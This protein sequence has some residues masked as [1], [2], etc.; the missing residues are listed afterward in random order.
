MDLQNLNKLQLKISV[1]IPCFNESLGIKIS[2]ERLYQVL[3]SNFNNFEI[4]YIN[5]GSTD[6]T[7]KCLS[8]IANGCRESKII[9]FSRNF[10]HQSA[11]SC[12][13]KNASGDYIIIMDADLQDPPEEIPK[14]VSLAIEQNA[15]GVYGVRKSRKGESF[16]KKITAK[17]FYRLINK[18]S[19]VE[20]PLDTGDFRLIDRNIADEFKNFGESHKYIRG[21]ISWIGYKQ[22][23]HYYHRDSR[24][25]GETNYSISKMFQFAIRGI[26]YFSKKP[27]QMATN[28]GLILVIGS[29]L[30]LIMQFLKWM[31][32]PNDFVMGWIS[33]FTA[34]VFFGGIQMLTIGILGTYI[35]NIFDEVKNRPEYIIESREN[36]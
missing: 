5:D 25:A 9:H 15:N 34:I 19:E 11:V 35:G 6:N 24:I 18:L 17:Y 16:F 14:M 13:I 4:L 27:L 8:E 28:I 21:I 23:P 2:H 7:K 29:F 3:R 12:G 20:F 31:Y 22:I 1:V 30:M 33:L 32:H 36:E 26:S 10:G